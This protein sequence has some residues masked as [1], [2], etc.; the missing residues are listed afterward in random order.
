MALRADLIIFIRNVVKQHGWTQK[1]T[2]KI[3]SITQPRVSDL[4]TGKID[5]FG[6]DKLITFIVSLG[7]QPTF[8]DREDDHSIASIRFEEKVA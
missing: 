7:F 6:L 1:E 2:A 5:K 8:S 3:L 4:L